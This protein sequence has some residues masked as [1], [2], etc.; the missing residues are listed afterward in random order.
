M[1]KAIISQSKF[2]ENMTD[3]KSDLIIDDFFYIRFPDVSLGYGQGL[4]VFKALPGNEYVGSSMDAHCGQNAKFQSK[5]L[6]NL[7]KSPTATGYGDM[8][9]IENNEQFLPYCVI[10]MA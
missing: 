10:N 7:D 2:C 6:Q 5:K 9:I 8:L 4:I 3:Q 1:E